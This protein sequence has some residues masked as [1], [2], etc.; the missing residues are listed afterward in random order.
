MGFMTP[1][2][3]PR[4][5]DFDPVP[6]RIV[7]EVLEAALAAADPEAAVRRNLATSRGSVR[8]GG[9]DH[10]A[11]KGR[12]IIL[13][14][15]KAAAAMARGAVSAL[16]GLAVTGVVVSPEPADIPG[17]E[18]VVGEHP[19]PG[20]RSVRGGQRLLEVA[21]AAGSDD[22]VLVLLSGGGSALAEV[23][24]PGC[25][26]ADLQAVGEQLLRSGLPIT[27]VNT[28]RRHLSALKGGRLALA[29]APA[30]VATLIV[31]DV[32]GSPL[33]AIAGGPTVPDP[34]SG[35]DARSVIADAG[36][37]VSPAVLE[38]LRRSPAARLA[39]PGLVAVIAD[40]P[41]C[42]T[43]GATAARA[44]G[45]TATVAA[46]PLLGEARTAGADLARGA[47]RLAPGVMVIHA[48]ETTVR[49]RGRGV[50]GRNHELALAA[51]IALEGAA[52][53]LVASLATDGVDGPSG[54]AGGIG[55]AATVE[56]GRVHGLA[57]AA[58]LDDNDSAT[59]LAATGDQ[60]RTGPTG[61]NVG[62]VA[63]AYRFVQGP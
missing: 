27:A 31:S 2:F 50:G 14:L 49:V 28:V 4:V 23:P 12:V 15:G 18:S 54:A 58:E 21:S 1:R 61:T 8:I 32:V 29:A 13:A 34:T 52:G 46:M 45:L 5:L 22:L 26:L 10:A 48:G 3:D 17:M 53:V 19:V 25:T 36:I 24:L 55:D 44:R 51:G 20:P 33:E 39:A 63:V 56:R 42:A 47:R 43:A 30:A 41:A 38:L 7:L 59:Y 35:A 9:S 6:R 37:T 16:E 60:L 57:A 40:G 11:P 62:D